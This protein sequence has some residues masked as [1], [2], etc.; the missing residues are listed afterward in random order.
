[1]NLTIKH[2]KPY[3]IVP[4][5][6]Y[7]ICKYTANPVMNEKSYTLFVDVKINKEGIEELIGNKNNY[8]SDLYID[9][10]GLKRT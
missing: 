2:K 4:L 3:S 6:K 10:T 9:C 5:D 8:K 1:M 7:N